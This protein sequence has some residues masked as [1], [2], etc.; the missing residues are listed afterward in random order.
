M[1]TQIYYDY[2]SNGE[3]INNLKNFCATINLHV[4]TYNTHSL[5][6]QITYNKKTKT[7]DRPIKNIIL[8]WSELKNTEKFEEI[9]NFCIQNLINLTYLYTIEKGFSIQTQQ[10]N[11]TS[12]QINKIIKTI[13]TTQFYEL[14]ANCTDHLRYTVETKIMDIK[15]MKKLCLEL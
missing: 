1:Y 15:N 12:I 7:K 3:D 8:I 5:I 9:K 6:K 13:Q 10:A 2:N 11:K 4:E 14:F